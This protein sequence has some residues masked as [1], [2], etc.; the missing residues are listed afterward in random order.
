MYL[1]FLEFS[2]VLTRQFALVST[3]VEDIFFFFF[4]PFLL[5]D[6]SLEASVYLMCCLSRLWLS[7]NS[8]PQY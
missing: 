7:L 8:D 2:A 3:V 4:F 6:H 1:S 5:F